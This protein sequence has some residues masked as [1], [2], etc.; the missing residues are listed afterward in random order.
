MRKRIH[1]Y[2]TLFTVALAGIVLAAA[3]TNYG[4]LSATG[5]R[6]ELMF[7]GEQFRQRSGHTMRVLRNAQA[8]PDSE[9]KLLLDDRSR[10]P[11]GICANLF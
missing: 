7:V 10:Y 2:L 6:S 3:G 8:F 1:L 4:K 9:E 5:K 11:N